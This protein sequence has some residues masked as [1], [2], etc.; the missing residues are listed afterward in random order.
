MRPPIPTITLST[1]A[2]SLRTFAIRLERHRGS[3]ESPPWVGSVIAATCNDIA[4]VLRA[5]AGTC[6]AV[7]PAAFE[8]QELGVRA[9][10]PEARRPGCTP[11]AES[12]VGR[13]WPGS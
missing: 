13:G 1:S 2:I 7:Q 5:S 6:S 12:A 11:E 10:E 3:F 9:E 4:G 8:S